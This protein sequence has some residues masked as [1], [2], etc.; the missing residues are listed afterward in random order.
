MSARYSSWGW[1]AES[2]KEEFMR[3]HIKPQTRVVMPKQAQLP[4]LYLFALGNKK[5]PMPIEML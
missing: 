5:E 4:L 3:K 1:M 2:Q